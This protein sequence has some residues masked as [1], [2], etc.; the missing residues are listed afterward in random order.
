LV[1]RYRERV[2]QKPLSAFQNIRTVYACQFFNPI[3]IKTSLKIFSISGVGMV[4][5]YDGMHKKLGAHTFHE[6]H[7]IARK[8]V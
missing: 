3:I 6:L 1:A 8:T 7:I 4:F 2:L 5:S